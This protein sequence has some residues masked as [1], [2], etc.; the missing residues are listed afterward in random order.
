MYWQ[1]W[2]PEGDPAGVVCL[3]HGLGEHSGRYGHV[4]ERLTDAGYAVFALD[5][6]GHG[7]SGGSRG[8][9]RV[10]DAVSDIADLVHDAKTQYPDIPSFLY[11]HSLGA[12]LSMTYAVRRSPSLNGVIA[13][14]PALDSEL[15][16]Q[17][18]KFFMANLLGSFAPGVTIPTGLDAQG[19]SRDPEV[20]QAYLDD[21]L[22]HDKGSL[23]LAKQTF[24]AMD[25][26]MARTDFPL[27][28][29][30]VHGQ[31]DRLT[32]PAASKRFC[33]Q[34]SGDVTLVEYDEM[35]HEPHNEPEQ[36]EVMAEVL[37]WMKAH[38]DN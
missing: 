24:E 30:I 14:A 20:V 23:G 6:R 15:R 17:K 38:S 27:P 12:L 18:V 26:M 37:T 2:L 8:D 33:E 21:P 28:L 36:A 19:V 9:L 32:V 31:A 25:Q 13:S 3:V 5:L 11:G 7:N 34:C 16:D 4:A 35:F 1:Q 10:P 22:V 29:L